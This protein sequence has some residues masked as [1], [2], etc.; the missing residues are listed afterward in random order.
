MTRFQTICLLTACCVIGVAGS[1]GYRF[2][3]S[4]E[5][6]PDVRE[7]FIRL[8]DNRSTETNIQVSLTDDLKNEYV[9]RYGGVLLDKEGSGAVLSGRISE[10]RTWTVSRSGTLA[11]L[12]RRIS[13]AVEAGLTDAT[14]KK[15]GPPVRVSAS[16]TY[17][18]A[19]G[20]KQASDQNKQEAISALSKQIA[21]AVFLR[22]AG[23]F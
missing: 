19:S 17:A 11:P 18:V 22:L 10:I 13:M 15:L 1:C 14:G 12:E 20:D 23:D 4:G 7:L 5:L 9:Q 2:T 16:E 3:G 8:F 21:E 6:P